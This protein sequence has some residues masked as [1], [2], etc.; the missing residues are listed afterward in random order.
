MGG[1]RSSASSKNT[2]KSKAARNTHLYSNTNTKNFR[3][4]N[5]EVAQLQKQYALMGKL[6]LLLLILRF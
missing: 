6:P 5:E 4:T 1:R 3:T 2:R